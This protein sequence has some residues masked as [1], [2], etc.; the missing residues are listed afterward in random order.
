MHTG[1]NELFA[2][3]TGGLGLFVVG[4]WL[5]APSVALAAI[6]GVSVFVPSVIVRSPAAIPNRLVFRFITVSVRYTLSCPPLAN[7]GDM[8]PTRQPPSRLP[9]TL[10]PQLTDSDPPGQREPRAF[11]AVVVDL[12]D[13]ES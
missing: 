3:V 7:V 12:R 4:M 1:T 9:P 11:C 10:S 2:G 5:L 13:C 8:H 6:P